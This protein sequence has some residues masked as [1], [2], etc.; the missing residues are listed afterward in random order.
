MRLP[1]NRSPSHPG[2]ILRDVYLAD[3]GMTQTEL[4]KKIGCSTA[5]ISEI[6]NGKRGITPEFAVDL[7]EA[8][9]TGPEI[10]ANMQCQFDLWHAIQK[11]RI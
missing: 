5:K 6:I 10:W 8:L 7:G 2:E 11:R 9:G 4:S 1:K 3:M